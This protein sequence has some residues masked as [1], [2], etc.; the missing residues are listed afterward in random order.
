MEVSSRFQ[1]MNKTDAIAVTKAKGNPFFLWVGRLDANKDPLTVVKAFGRFILHEPLAM[2]YM[3]YHTEDLKEE[4]LDMIKKEN[5]QNNIIMVG[6][7]PHQEMQYWYSSA[8]FIISGSH[9]EGSGV[10]VC[11]AMSCG[12]IPV[13]T[14]ITSF[15]KM[16]GPGKCGLLY[17]PGDVDGL[18]AALLKTRELDLENERN[19]VLQQFNEELSFEVIAE[20]INRVITSQ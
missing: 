8:G 11:E 3:I 12:C 4:A 6:K 14:N 18:L 7:V 13:L 16:T 10:A 2:L 5:L 20:K 17:E 1:P 15:R 19:K 9:Y